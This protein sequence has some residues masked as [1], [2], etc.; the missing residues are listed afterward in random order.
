MPRRPRGPSHEHD[1]TASRRD[2]RVVWANTQKSQPAHSGLL[3]LCH[4]EGIDVIHVQEPHTF[5]P[6]R[7]Q[8]HPSYD[9]FTPVQTWNRDATLTQDRPRVLS[10]VRRRPGLKAEQPP[11]SESRDLL[12]I[13]VN[14]IDMLNVYRQPETDSS[15]DYVTSLVAPERFLLGG[16]F[17]VKHSRFEPNTRP[18]NG[19]DRLARWADEQGLGFI[20]Q[21]GEATHNA[22]H[23]LDLTFSNLPFATTRVCLDMDSGA[24]HRTLLTTIPRIQET[25]SACPE[26]KVTDGKL[27]D[28]ARLVGSYTQEL[29]VIGPAP[30]D[31][32]IEE[33]AGALRQILTEAIK[34]MGMTKRQGGRAAP[35]WTPACQEAHKSYTT[36]LKLARQGGCTLEEVEDARRAF[37]TMTRKEKKQHWQQV[38]DNATDDSKFYTILNWHK[39]GPRFKA[40]PLTV[41]NETIYT[42]EEKAEALRDAVLNRFS[43]DDDLS[44]DPLENGT[45]SPDPLPWSLEISIEEVEANTIGVCTTSPGTDGVSVRLLKAAWPH[46]GAY[47]HALYRACIQNGYYPQA[48]R[49]AEVVMLPKAGKDVSSP[50]AWRPIALISCVAKGLE[51]LLAK[52]I[53]W[54]ALTHNLIS[55]QHGGALPRRSG[56]DLV[57]SLSHDIES[58]LAMGQEVT[59]VTAD[60]QGAFDALLPRRLLARM[61]KDGWPDKCLRVIQCF[62]DKRRVRVRLEDY[63]TMFTT[64]ACGTPQGSPLS[65]VLFTLYMAE[66]LRKDRQLRFGYADDICLYRAS[67][68]LYTNIQKLEQDLRAL[69]RWS[70]ENKVAFAPEKFEMLHISRKHNRDNPPLQVDG[71]RIDPVPLLDGDHPLPGLRWLGVWFDRRLNFRRHVVERTNKAMKVARHMRSLAAVQ[72]GPGAAVMRKAVIACVLPSALYGAEAWYAG[73]RRSSARGTDVSTRKGWHI[74]LINAVI[75][76]AARA[77]LP[78][79]KTTPNMTILR[80]AGLPTGELALEQ[81]KSRQAVRIAAVEETHPLTRRAKVGTYKTGKNHGLPMRRR[82]QLQLL[83]EGITE[84]PPRLDLVPP[85]Y[86]TG[87]RTN[88]TGGVS[89]EDAAVAFSSWTSSLPDQDMV[90]YTDGSEFNDKGTRKVGYGYT[91]IRDKNEVAHGQG[92]IHDVSHVFDAEGIAALRGLQRAVQLHQETPSGHIWL[93]IDSTSVI[94]CARGKAATSSQWAFL[95]L[96]ELLDSSRVTIKWCPGHQDIPGNERADALARAGAQHG[97]T[98]PEADRPSLSGV[99]TA[100]A[101]SFRDSAASWWDECQ[102]RLSQRY[103]RWSLPYILKTP[104]ELTLPRAALH[105]LLATRTGHGNFAW[106]HRRFHPQAEVQNECECG[107]DTAPEHIVHC[108]KSR[109]RWNAEAG[110]LSLDPIPN[111]LTLRIPFLVELFKRPQLFLLFL[112]IVRP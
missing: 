108:R 67:K 57:A 36:L 49:E 15:L 66:V 13:R 97:P 63:R 44:E 87:C 11:G 50:R 48:W 31:A 33:A 83:A 78:I 99:R 10:Y 7:T 46:V 82:T 47:V 22:G 42:T 77:V 12:W 90:V 58:A 4:R 61:R 95:Q 28:F 107:E 60:I 112:S 26:I 111:D 72:H 102:S 54:T 37:H 53:A 43:A 91:I 96:H 88:P 65:P 20:G 79:W 94:W 103:R 34:T 51:R 40:P 84:I 69:L 85:H 52:R 6:S 106:Y 14:E 18:A 68:S 64:V 16:D 27:P 98:D 25:T 86:S 39:L 32:R 75:V 8:N 38:I 2:L 104:P 35:W 74:D 23:V 81:L 55:P 73:R 29:P 71:L 24:D 30:N 76:M 59:I 41:G 21:V 89:K 92:R 93:C 5:A 110:R 70:S 19:G 9:I 3:S 56:T 105:T 101:R 1:T 80:D 17:N 100:Q 62:L 45:E 109:Q